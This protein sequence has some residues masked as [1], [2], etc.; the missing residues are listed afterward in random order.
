MSATSR[1]EKELLLAMLQERERRA[2]V[3][4]YK[5]LHR[6]LYGWQRE[7]NANTATHTQV[8]LI[9]ANR[10]GKTYTG[11]YLD[12]IHTLGD[13]PDDWEG[14]TFGHAPLVWCL[15]TPARR[16]ATCCRNRS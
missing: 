3:Y 9:A 6:N 4:R 10:I 5:A 12:A 7:F 1:A 13:Y 15:A 8:C 2:R 11:T 16:R 14:H